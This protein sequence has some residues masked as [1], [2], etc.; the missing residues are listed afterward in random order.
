MYMNNDLHR[1][2]QYTK[3]DIKKEKRKKTNMCTHQHLLHN[4]LNVLEKTP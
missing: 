2:L 1:T 4:S 3:K